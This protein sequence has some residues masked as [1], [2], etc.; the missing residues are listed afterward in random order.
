MARVVWNYEIPK[1]LFELPPE[2]GDRRTACSGFT[3]VKPEIGAAARVV[4][5]SGVY[6]RRWQQSV[7]TAKRRFAVFMPQAARRVAL[8][9]GAESSCILLIVGS[10]SAPP[11]HPANGKPL[12]PP[13]DLGVLSGQPADPSRCRRRSGAGV[14]PAGRSQAGRYSAL[15]QAGNVSLKRPLVRVSVCSLR[16]GRMLWQRDLQAWWPER[17]RWHIAPAAWP[18]VEDLDGNGRCDL[19][20]PDGTSEW[21]SRGLDS[22]PWGELVRL[23]GATGEVRWRRRIRCL[24]QSVDR[25]TVGPDVD[26]DGTRDVFSAVFWGNQ[27]DVYVDATSGADGQSL[28]WLRSQTAVPQDRIDNQL[29]G[30][31]FWWSGDKDGMPLL[32]V[33]TTEIRPNEIA[34]TVACVSVQHGQRVHHATGLGLLEAADLDGDGVRELLSYHT[35]DRQEMID[36]GGRLNAFR[37]YAGTAWRRLG[38]SPAPVGDL[39][40]D[41]IRDLAHDRGDGIYQALSGK[42][43]T[44][45]WTVDTRDLM[46]SARPLRIAVEASTADLDGDGVPDPIV[47]RDDL[48]TS[49]STPYPLLHALSGRTGRRLWSA[50]MQLRFIRTVVSVTS[51]DLDGDGVNEILWIGLGDDG[52]KTD[53]LPSWQRTRMWLVVLDGRQGR[54]RW[55]QALSAEH[56]QPDQPVSRL[57]GEEVKLP[58]GIGDLDGDGVL[59]VVVPVEVSMEPPELE[60]QAFS[61]RDGRRLWSVP[62]EL[63]RRDSNALADL[64]PCTVTDLDADGVVEVLVLDYV[65]ETRSDGVKQLLQRVRAID[66]KTGHERWT[67]QFPVAHAVSHL[68]HS[69]DRSLRPRVTVLRRASSEPW[70]GLNLWTSP[71]ELVVLDHQG[72]D[73]SRLQLETTR[74]V[75]QG[76][77]SVH[78]CDTDGDGSDELVLFHQDALIAARPETPGQPLWRW[79]VDTLNSH[80]VTQIMEPAGGASPTIVVQSPHGDNQVVGLNAATGTLRWICAGPTSRV[81]D[82]V[83]VMGDAVVLADA[84]AVGPPRL[85]FQHRAMS[86]SLLG[87]RIPDNGAALPET[88]QTDAALAVNWRSAPGTDPRYLRRFPGT[89]P[90]VDW[91]EILQALAW[92]CYYSA[93]LLGVPLLYAT[94]LMRRRQWSLRM[95]LVLPGVVLVMLIAI[96]TR[97]SGALFPT[98]VSRL[99]G[100]VAT[101]PVLWLVY[102]VIV[103]AIQSQ[104]RRAVN[105]TAVFLVLLLV[106]FMIPWI[107]VQINRTELIEDGE[108]L[109][110]ENSQW[111]L[112]PGA[113]LASWLLVLWDLCWIVAAAVQR[114][115]RREP[116]V[117][118]AESVS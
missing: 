118:V 27:G 65:S 7:S 72:N 83:E 81:A 17:P 66:G 55:K 56:G 97:A 104:W 50:A 107:I 32:A 112:I 14:D 49:T 68:H 44:S 34:Y 2:R 24:D 86:Q 61:G 89:P 100:A 88:K 35:K 117:L 18:V 52:L 20:V 25:F 29:L 73:V 80:R 95:W 90:H 113:F 62:V 46:S 79:P 3:G 12:A 96:S 84:E 1:A 94:R 15:D 38:P 28:Y 69:S 36:Y 8:P 19:L 111:L 59:D 77:F 99:F 54:V 42:D 108:R 93:L 16:D 116:T 105:R 87:R 48:V 9:D 114:R 60:Y 47:Y 110:F 40:G 57:R 37:G 74:G 41:G 30:P 6:T 92:S 39:N 64:L 70:L 10:L 11:R 91:A 21:Q 101:L 45:L 115:L 13:A 67:R 4:L 26:G 78:A 58:I 22:A 51:A 109:T 53:G 63:P 103:W 85:L 31:L 71:E 102:R 98:T 23:D 106:A 75:H 5:G 33:P 82:Y 43:A 76:R